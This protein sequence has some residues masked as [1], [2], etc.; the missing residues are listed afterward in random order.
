MRVVR[1]GRENPLP[2]VADGDKDT[3]AVSVKDADALRETV[4]L[5]AEAD[6]PAVTVGVAVG[7]TGE[8]DRDA[9]GVTE[10]EPVP[11]LVDVS[12]LDSDPPEAVADTACVAVMEADSKL[13]AVGVCDGVPGV[14]DAVAVAH[15]PVGG[16]VTLRV[17][18]SDARVAVRD[19]ERVADRVAAVAVCI[20]VAVTVLLRTAEAERCERDRD[21]VV[22]LDICRTPSTRRRLVPVSEWLAV[23][24]EVPSNE[25]VADIE[26][27]PDGVS[28]S[29]AV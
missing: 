2:R 19:G 28:V 20:A 16:L 11:V 22:D 21:F 6:R 18:D 24:V 23:R 17:R 14:R 25:A 10:A 5:A 13:V 4:T 15:E 7:V 26:I 1:L 8:C 27:E 12:S 29:V 9:V 3:V